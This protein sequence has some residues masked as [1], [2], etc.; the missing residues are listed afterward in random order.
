[1]CI[2]PV[3]NT[4]LDMFTSIP[5]FCFVSFILMKNPSPADSSFSI[6]LSECLCKWWSNGDMLLCKCM[7]IVVI[8]HVS[9]FT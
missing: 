7:H 1:M 5:S 9:R 8:V 2:S 3:I 6:M 4:N